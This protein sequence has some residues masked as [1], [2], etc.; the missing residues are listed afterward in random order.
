M[1]HSTLAEI[2]DWYHYISPSKSGNHDVGTAVKKFQRFFHLPETG[3][4][5]EETIYQMKK[6]RC[7]DPDVEEEASRFK[8]YDSVTSWSKTDFTYYIQYSDQDLSAADQQ[9][10]IADA[11]QKWINACNVLTF[12]QTNDYTNPDF[13]IG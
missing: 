1:F 13:K 6:P 5:D 3:E 7:G 4:V 9:S 11:F 2:S 10:A 8:R 12:T